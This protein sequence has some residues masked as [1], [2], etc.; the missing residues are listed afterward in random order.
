MGRNRCPYGLF[1]IFAVFS[2]DGTM[3]KQK[4]RF[5]KIVNIKNRKARY[6]YEFIDTLVAGIVLSGSEIKSI[7]EQKASLQQ[8]YCYIHQGELFVK[9]M[10][11][12]PYQQ[13]SHFNHEPTRERKLLLKKAEIEKLDSK[14]SEKGLA[15]IPTRLF[16]NDRGL[17]KLEVALARGKKLHDK[18]DSIKEK[19]QKRELDRMKF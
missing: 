17:A 16:I 1:T 18:R 5:S 15:M 12:S 7:R 14:M 19:D 10:H 9:D 6:E 13:A 8:A 4:E 3:A 11:I 2:I